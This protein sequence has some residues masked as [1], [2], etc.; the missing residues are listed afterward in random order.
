M[1]GG[2]K[3]S[4][5]PDTGRA[6]ASDWTEEEK[7]RGAPT[8]AAAA[9]GGTAGAAGEAVPKAKPSDDRAATEAAA[10]EQAPDPDRPVG[11]GRGTRSRGGSASDPGAAEKGTAP[12]R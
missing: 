5:I 7:A 8:D 3:P 10:A 1:S 6:A 4:D 12:D 2:G 11:G 9:R